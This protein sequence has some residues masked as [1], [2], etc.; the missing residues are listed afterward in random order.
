METSEIGINAG[1]IWELIDKTG[2][3]HIGDIKKK[4]KLDSESLYMA[5][6]CLARETE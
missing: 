1:I 5:L 4:T 2:S 3:L 6:G